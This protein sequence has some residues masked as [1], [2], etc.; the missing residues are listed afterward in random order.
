MARPIKQGFSYFPL[1]VHFFSDIRIRK[2]I[3]NNSSQAVSIYLCVLTF[4]YENGYYVVND[5]DLGFVIS[6]KTGCK[7]SMVN[8]VLSYCVAIGLFS[9]EMYK[10]G[11][12]TSKSIQE[13]YISMCKSSK[14]V[15]SIGE[16]RLV[17][18]EETPISSEETPVSSEKSTQSKVKKSKVNNSSSIHA[19]V[20]THTRESEE[21]KDFLKTK[22]QIQMNR[23]M[24]QYQLSQEELNAKIDEFVD[25]KT[26]W[27]ENSWNNTS[28]L[29]RNFEFWLG[30]NHRKVANP[31]KYWTKKD[32]YEQV[33]AIEGV[34]N[35]TKQAFY[36]YYS[37]TA[38]DGTMLF[39]NLKAWNTETMIKKWLK[40]ENKK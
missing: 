12:F 27:G 22:Q 26:S 34:K 38:E 14:R 17:S 6:E 23:L 10:Q 19:C 35:N 11:V 32:F 24:M 5:R 37:Q 36:N 39:Q 4:I 28:D 9:D 8:A 33:K 18:S 3:K 15:V 31:Y 29:A 1:D 16:F 30:K 25:K 40:N 21:V 13:R 20:P 2:L 7:E